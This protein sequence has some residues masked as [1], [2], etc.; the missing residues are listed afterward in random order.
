VGCE[1]IPLEIVDVLLVKQVV[2]ANIP[3]EKIM[4]SLQIV[5][6]SSRLNLINLL[7]SVLSINLNQVDKSGQ[8]PLLLV[9]LS[10]LTQA[11]TI[12]LGCLSVEYNRCNNPIL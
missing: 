11:A 7:V 6:G 12:L 5:V 9:V 1:E 8:T 10:R 3:R 2:D 4:T